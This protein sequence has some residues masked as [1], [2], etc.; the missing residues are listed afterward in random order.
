MKNK[1]IIMSMF[2][3]TI[4]ITAYFF[5][6]SLAIKEHISKDMKV[7]FP[8]KFI[9]YEII[10]CSFGINNIEYAFVGE[11][12]DRIEN[13]KIF[14][15]NM[16]KGSLFAI[17]NWSDD[18]IGGTTVENTTFDE[19]VKMIKED[20]SQFQEDFDAEDPE[21]QIDWGYREA[22]PPKSKKAIENEEKQS[23]YEIKKYLDELG[24]YDSTMTDYL[25]ENHGDWKNL[26][27]EDFLNW[28]TEVG[29]NEDTQR[30][31]NPAYFDE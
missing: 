18:Y 20:C 5:A 14:F 11:Y 19:L 4:G 3:I 13:L 7:D 28:A 6:S 31:I 16:K 29:E 22:D 15:Y 26:S 2:L 1:I 12:K 25:I 8:D 17:N 24:A 9:N 21:T 30:V 27:D 23:I 10:K